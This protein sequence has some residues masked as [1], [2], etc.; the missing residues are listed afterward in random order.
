MGEARA[1]DTNL[2]RYE[3]P[4]Y[5]PLNYKTD[6]VTPPIT[7]GEK[8]GRGFSHP[9]TG[10]LLCPLRYLDRFQA[11]PMWAHKV[12]SPASFFFSHNRQPLQESSWKW[13]NQ[14]SCKPREELAIFPLSRR[15]SVW[16]IRVGERPFSWSCFSTCKFAFFLKKKYFFFKWYFQGLR[17][18]FTGKSSAFTGHRAASKPSQ[19]E[20]HG[21]RKVFPE[22]VAYAAVQVR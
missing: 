5:I 6:S 4:K 1:Q 8:S 11:D 19:A 13:L 21:M 18:L 16:R 12:I 7:G 9:A 15:Y 10:K 22:A 17:A 3:I 14:T 20:M 2:L